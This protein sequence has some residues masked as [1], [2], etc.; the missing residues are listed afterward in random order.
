MD[1]ANVS[2]LYIDAM[3][4]LYMSIIV[5]FIGMYLNKR[6]SFLTEYYI[7]P[8]VTGGLLFSLITAVMYG[9]ADIQLEFDMRFRDLLLI[10]ALRTLVVFPL[11]TLA[12]LWFTT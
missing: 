11:L 7:P 2:V 12:G 8:A 1:A 5:L 10:F 9:F 3:D 4:M 6:I